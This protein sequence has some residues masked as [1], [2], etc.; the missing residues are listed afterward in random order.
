MSADLFLKVRSNL[1]QLAVNIG[2]C[3]FNGVGK[4]GG[5][6]F[7]DGNINDCLKSI[8]M[9]EVEQAPHTAYSGFCLCL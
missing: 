8:G 5:Y 6:L 3:V 4:G 1:L 9:D 7:F 2:V